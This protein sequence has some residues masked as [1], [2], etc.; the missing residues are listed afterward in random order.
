MPE[1]ASA[2]VNVTVTSVLFQAAPFASGQRLPTI[3]GGVMSMLMPATDAALLLPARS[4]KVAVADCAAPSDPIVASL[5][6]VPSIPESAST[7]W[8]ATATGPL[9]QP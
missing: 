5:L 4:A 9:F 1:S 8:N 6:A 3:V 7:A 2:H